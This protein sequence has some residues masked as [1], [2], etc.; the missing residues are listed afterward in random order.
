MS[1]ISFLT[2]HFRNLFYFTL[3]IIVHE[4][5]HFLTGKILCFKVQKIEIYPYGGCSKLEY[6][7]NTFLWKEWLVLLMGPF[8]QCVFVFLVCFL[9]VDVPNY[10]Y[11]YHIFILIFN[12]LPIYPLDGG[13]LVNLFLASLF[14]YYQSIRISFYF[15]FFV[16]LMIFFTILLFKWNL[17]YFLIMISLGIKIYKEIRQAD[18]YFQ[19]FLME[20]YFHTY[21]FCKIKNVNTIKQ[22]KRDYYHLFIKKNGVYSEKKVLSDYFLGKE[23]V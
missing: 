16:Y 21:P 19:K 17:I 23:I 6:D 8:T 12:L 18:Y 2:G 4:L 15:S 10:F 1:F 7:I 9:K 5:G 22:M 20:R 11:H 14:S 13:R 3:L